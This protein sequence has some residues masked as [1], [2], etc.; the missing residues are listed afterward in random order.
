MSCVERNH[1]ISGVIITFN[2]EM[3]IERCID[4]L[5][6]VCDEIIVVDSYS[7]DRTKEICLEKGVIFIENGFEGHIQQKNYA[8]EQANY[9]YVLSLD[10][11][12]ELSVELAESILEIKGN[13]NQ[14]AYKFNRFTNYCGKWIKHS[15]WYPDTKIRLWD[16]RKARWGGTNPHDQVLISKNSAAHLSG[17][18]L[19]YSYYSMSEHIERSARYAKI[20]A[21]AMH[22]NGKKYSTLNLLVN[23]IYRFF[24]DYMINKGFLD[25]YEGFVICVTNGYTTFLK[26]LYLR[27]LKKGLPV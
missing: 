22:L 23:P 4:S 2:E 15:G 9:N 24:K 12:E 13:L 14:E 11:D 5:K 25:G 26:Y 17:D 21:N 16:K 19:H 1:S 8:L 6:I 27:A 18:L 20:A 7:Q 3:N 10:A